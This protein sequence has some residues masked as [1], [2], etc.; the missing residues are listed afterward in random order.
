MCLNNILHSFCGPFAPSRFSFF[1]EPHIGFAS[2]Y[3]GGQPPGNIQTNGRRCSAFGTRVGFRR[4]SSSYRSCFG[5][6][7]LCARVRILERP[8]KILPIAS[9]GR[10]Y[11][12]S[13]RSGSMAI[14]AN[15][16]CVQCQGPVPDG[17]ARFCSDACLAQYKREQERLT[18]GHCHEYRCVE[19]GHQLHLG[20]PR[21]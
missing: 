13:F 20:R 11:W 12:L 14:A 1:S 10:P 17:R 18:Y 6:Y 15:V 2:R 21:R 4:L 3:P 9:E 5:F 19:C 16:K 8:Q 7:E